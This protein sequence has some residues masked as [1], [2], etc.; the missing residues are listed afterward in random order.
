MHCRCHWAHACVANY[1]INRTQTQ[2]SSAV[3]N[4]HLYFYISCFSKKTWIRCI[5]LLKK[6]SLKGKNSV[7]T[8]PSSLKVN[9][10]FDKYLF[11]IPKCRADS[12][13]QLSVIS[14]SR[15]QESFSRLL[16]S[17]P[18]TDTISNEAPANSWW[19]NWIANCISMTLT[20]CSSAAVF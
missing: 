10:W 2:G 1:V 14:L 17:H 6:Y 18:S 11:F 13:R 4:V 15:L 19:I 5:C 7:C 8:I 16:H 12:L 3:F 20:Y 9:I